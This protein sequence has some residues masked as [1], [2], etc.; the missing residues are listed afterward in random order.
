MTQSVE[1]L[2]FEYEII[3]IDDGST[4][5][6]PKV[7]QDLYHQDREHVRSSSSGA[8]LARWRP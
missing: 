6:S 3:F 7:L 1:P 5:R 2:P 4:D 8:I